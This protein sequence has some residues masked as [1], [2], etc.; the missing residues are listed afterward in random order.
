[1]INPLFSHRGSHIL[2]YAWDQP[3]TLESLA[4]GLFATVNLLVLLVLFISYNAVIT[5][6][7]FLY[8]F[9]S[10]F[11]KIALLIV[12]AMRFVPLLKHRLAGIS[13]VQQMKG[14]DPV[15]AACGYG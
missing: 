7:R 1:M 15:M 14:I 2:F 3:V 9:G 8:L 11:P 4:Y 5:P 13:S 12:M 6:A 10:L